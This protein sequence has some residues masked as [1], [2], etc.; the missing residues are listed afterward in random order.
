[1]LSQVRQQSD[2]I[3]QAYKRLQSTPMVV[4]LGLT[5][6]EL[7]WAV[8]VVTSRSF[9]IPKHWID[10]LRGEAPCLVGIL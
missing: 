7:V 1:M 3:Q 2:T 6:E 5:L 8:D 4:K 10:T 9:A